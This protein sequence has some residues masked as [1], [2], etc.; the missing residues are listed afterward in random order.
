MNTYYTYNPTTYIFVSF[1]ES[2][3]QPPHS[4]TKSPGVSRLYHTYKFDVATDD[5]IEG[6]D[7]ETALQF[8]TEG[9][10][11]A[12]SYFYGLIEET[13]GKWRQSLQDYGDK[14]PEEILS[15]IS[16]MRADLLTEILRFDIDFDLESLKSKIRMKLGF[17]IVIDETVVLDENN[18]PI[19][20]ELIGI[21]SLRFIELGSEK[22]VPQPTYDNTTGKLNHSVNFGEK[23]S[24]EFYAY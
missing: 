9:I 16:S 11:N 1:V 12:R 21:P 3:I 13:I 19:I 2:E 6:A 24:F 4:T 23:Y 18:H 7:A 20:P 15:Q 10:F 14:I 17:D 22:M 5:W 8:R